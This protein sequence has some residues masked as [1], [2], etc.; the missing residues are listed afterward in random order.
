MELDFV[1]NGHANKSSTDSSDSSWKS[2]MVH[3]LN[4][5]WDNSVKDYY[6]YIR[7]ALGFF[8]LYHEILNWIAYHRNFSICWIISEGWLYNIYMDVS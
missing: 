1:K 8:L 5:E 4:R 6:L 2:S 3:I 7:Y